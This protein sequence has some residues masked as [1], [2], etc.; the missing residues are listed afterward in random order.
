MKDNQ[1]NSKR[2]E[3]GDQN[4]SVTMGDKRTFQATIAKVGA[5]LVDLKVNGQS[6]VLGYPEVEDYLCD[7]GNLVDATVGRYANRIY[8][9]VFNTPST[10][11]C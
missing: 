6:V 8:K 2:Q 4:S 9:G 1:E 11:D 10:V 5:T 7:A 3:Y